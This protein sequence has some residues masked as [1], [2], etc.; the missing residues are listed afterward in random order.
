MGPGE[1]T[2]AQTAAQTPPKMAQTPPRAIPLLQTPPHAGSARGSARG[3]GRATPV[4]MPGA[5]STAQ[6]AAYY[7]ARAAESALEP[8]FREAPREPAEIER[9]SPKMVEMARRAEKKAARLAWQY[10][11]I[12]RTARR[13]AE[14]LSLASGILGGLVGTGGLVGAASPGTN[15]L[16]G[17]TSWTTLASIVIGYI[18]GVI[19]V[20]NSNW[21]L[22][23]L[24][25]KG[26]TAQLGL[27]AVGREI[28]WQL[29]QPA[30][31][32]ADA[33]EFI[34]AR[35]AEIAALEAAGPPRDEW[36]R[37]RY[38]RQC[39]AGAAGANEDA[40]DWTPPDTPEAAPALAQALAQAPAQALAQAPAQ[41]EVANTAA[42][43][44][45]ALAPHVQTL[46]DNPLGVLAFLVAAHGAATAA[47]AT[48]APQ[49]PA[50]PATA[51]PGA[52]TII[53][54]PPR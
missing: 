24:Q 51:V 8:S 39:A 47:P 11:L 36:V 20:V 45:A 37:E 18:I 48:A 27:Q 12:A 14:R 22:G 9:W 42:A 52:E 25:M 32:R 19:S 34:H 2:A 28:R 10:E 46:Q 15:A 13:T 54:M 6:A 7:V 43:V 49:A 4:Y 38:L 21:R 53:E 1:Q 41:N 35:E 33:Y 17:T 50:A 16:V 3:S 5:E 40:L 30:A 26:V 29:A 44:A 23:E 31:D